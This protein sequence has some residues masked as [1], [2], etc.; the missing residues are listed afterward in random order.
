MSITLKKRFKNKTFLFR[1]GYES[2]GGNLKDILPIGAAIEFM[3]IATL[4]IDDILDE[5]EI[6]NGRDSVYKNGVLKFYISR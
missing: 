6:R 5:S 3:Q 2:G 1:I 4:V